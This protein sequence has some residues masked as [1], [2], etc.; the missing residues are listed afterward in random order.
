MREAA[1]LRRQAEKDG[2]EAYL[3]HP[4]VRGRPNSRFLTATV[5]G[6]QQANKAV[7][8]NE[9]WRVRQKE[10]ELDDRLRGNSRDRN[11]TSRR[12]ESSRPSIISSHE[13][14]SSSSPS[15]KRISEDC[16][17]REDQGLKDEELEEFL[18]SRT[19]RGRGAVG[20]RMDETGPYL[21]PCNESDS[22]WPTCSNFTDRRVVHGPEKPNSLKSDSSSEEEKD[23]WKRSKR[24]SHKQHRK[25]HK[26]KHK[27]E[28]KR[29][30]ESK[31]SKRHK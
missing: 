3:R 15:S 16:D 25:D 17:L 1:E 30:K 10:L 14:P 22:S 11:N 13:I 27:S 8:V 29:R 2:V 5:L 23:R 4:K 9:M 26:S 20:S 19:K 7:E 6:V 24:S 31:K 21:A 28:K 18:H 12:R